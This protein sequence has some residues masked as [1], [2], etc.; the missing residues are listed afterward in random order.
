MMEQTHHRLGVGLLALL[1]ALQLAACSDPLLPEETVA[2]VEI[3]T[4]L[5]DWLVRVPGVVL[6]EDGV[7][8]GPT[9]SC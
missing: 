3:T 2:T 9:R 5:R 4:E 1:G 8:V 6:L 7:A